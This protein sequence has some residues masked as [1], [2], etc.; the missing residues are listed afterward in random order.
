MGKTWSLL[1]KGVIFKTFLNPG[2]HKFVVLP[3]TGKKYNLRLD[4]GKDMYLRLVQRTWAGI[5]PSTGFELVTKEQ[6]EL[7]ISQGDLAPPDEKDLRPTPSKN[8]VN[9]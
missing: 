8:H 9:N 6:G 2:G 5:F 7:D 3:S 1:R 4:Q